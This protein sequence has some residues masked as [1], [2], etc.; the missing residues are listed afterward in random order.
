MKTTR[1]HS[2]RAGFA[3]TELV[4]CTILMATLS[5]I[6]APTLYAIRNQQAAIRFESLAEME[7]QNLI[8]DLATSKQSPEEMEASEWFLARYPDAVLSMDSSTEITDV[9]P[10]GLRPITLKLTLEDSPTKTPLRRSLTTWIRDSAPADAADTA[11]EDTAE[12]NP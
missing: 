10:A 1:Q 2:P 9:T 7:L 3:M 12:A 11:P 5:G 8:A 4:A 6:L